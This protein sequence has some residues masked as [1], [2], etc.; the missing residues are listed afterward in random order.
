[1]TINFMESRKCW[2]EDCLM[3]QTTTTWGEGRSEISLSRRE[4]VFIRN[5]L[6]EELMQQKHAMEFLQARLGEEEI[7]AFEKPKILLAVSVEIDRMRPVAALIESNPDG[8][9]AKRQEQTR[10]RAAVASVEINFATVIN[11]AAS[12]SHADQLMTKD[13]DCGRF[14]DIPA[15]TANSVAPISEES[16]ILKLIGESEGPIGAM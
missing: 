1:M 14:G 2:R 15:R 11:R 3:R 5:N 13:T 9:L 12:A 6:L 7:R 16:R 8:R 10:R 4:H